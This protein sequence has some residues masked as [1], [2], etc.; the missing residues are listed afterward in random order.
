MRNETSDVRYNVCG[1]DEYPG[2]LVDMQVMMDDSDHEWVDQLNIGTM[3]FED[4]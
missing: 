2:G 4:E 3:R 1:V